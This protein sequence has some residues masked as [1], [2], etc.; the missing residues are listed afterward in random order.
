MAFLEFYQSIKLVTCPLFTFSLVLK[1]KGPNWILWMIS[2]HGILSLLPRWK[3]FAKQKWLTKPC[4]YLVVVE[5]I[6]FTKLGSPLPWRGI[7][8][9]RALCFLSLY[10]EMAR[11]HVLASEMW[12]DMTW[13]I[14]REWF[15]G[16][17]MSSLLSL[18]L[19]RNWGFW[20]SEW[21]NHNLEVTLDLKALPG[22][23]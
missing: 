18:F 6:L 3:R 21:W 2:R 10:P 16:A 12:A 9:A 7:W 23:K 15:Y 11:W 1:R 17:H 19:A 4:S 8:P 13:V 5:G 14:S 22:I 20:A